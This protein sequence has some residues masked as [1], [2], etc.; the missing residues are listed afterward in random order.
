MS[1]AAYIAAGI[2]SMMLTNLPT[3]EPAKGKSPFCD[4]EKWRKRSKR[5]GKKK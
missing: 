3:P 1:R 5:R 4:A 2:A